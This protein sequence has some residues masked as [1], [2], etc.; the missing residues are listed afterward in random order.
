[1]ADT[2]FLSNQFKQKKYLG[3]TEDEFKDN[4]ELWRKENGY[5]KFVDN[6][7]QADLRNIGIRPE[8]DAT[9]TPGADL[10]IEDLPDAP[11]DGTD[12]LGINTTDT[13]PN[14]IPGGGT[15][16]I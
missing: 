7:K 15:P 1:M 3:L 4:E 11:M 13:P 9:V 2:P 16:E 6:E 10:G 8:S 14:Q 12:D 5:E